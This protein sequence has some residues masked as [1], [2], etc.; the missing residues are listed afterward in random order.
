MRAGPARTSLALLALL[1]AARTPAVAADGPAGP[2]AA[3]LV[4]REFAAAIKTVT[5]ATVV[6]VPKGAAAAD[7]SMSSGVIVSKVGHVLSDGDAGAYFAG[8]AG[9]REKRF[10]DKIEVRVPDLKRGTFQ[11]FTAKV[12]RRIEALDTCLMKVE[13]PPPS[14]F[15]FVLPRTAEDLRVG[16]F[17]FAM[18]TPFGHDEGG[19]AALTAGIVSALVP[20]PAGDAGGKHALVYTSA[21]VNPG[22]NGG[23]LVDADGALVGIISTWSGPEPSNPYQF[24]GKAFPIDRLRAAYRDLPD[25]A[26][27][28]PDPKSLAPRSKQAAL[29][30]AAFSLAAAKAYPSVAS[31]ELTRGE[32]FHMVVGR[33]PH[34]ETVELA[35]YTGPV[36]GVVVS[37]DGWIVTSLYNL[38]NVTALAA[39]AGSGGLETTLAKITGIQA[40]FTDGTSAP[41]RLVAHDQKLGIACLKADLPAGKTTVPAT[42][43][44]REAAAPGRL[45]LCVGNPFG[46]ARSPEPLLTVGMYSRLHPEDSD[47]AWRGDF[48]TD[49]GLTDAD[50]GGALVDVHGRVMGLAMLWNPA[51]HGR[52]SGIGFGVPWPTVLAALPSLQAGTSVTYGNAYLGVV[53]SFDAAAGGVRI[54]QTPKKPPKPGE[55]GGGTP[56]PAEVAGVVAG[57]L[58]TAIDGKPI[59][60][61]RDATEGVRL[62]KPGDKVRLTI[63]RDG[64]TLEIEVTLGER[65]TDA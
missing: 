55:T 3:A 28:F 45:V 46:A 47:D 12:L 29:L 52:S 41:A 2:G 53:W 6:C 32:P 42:P 56:G 58:V 27:V 15:P 20:L 43:A 4:E 22:V 49:A 24:L 25:A 10:A 54:D 61:F 33:G 9:K 65:P 5:P 14:G 18:G 39:N 16:S 36:S 44:P 26:S 48:Q 11:V 57:D 35:R 7:E 64:K 59:K 50:C 34:G 23:P 13:S 51:Q 37:S 30:E 40:H 60:R 19:T 8:A 38:G 1:A 31:L 63:A 17:T 62:R 21:A